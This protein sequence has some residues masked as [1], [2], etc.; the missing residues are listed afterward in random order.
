MFLNILHFRKH[1]ACGNMNN[2]N[3]RLICVVGTFGE[4]NR[5]PEIFRRFISSGLP[6]ALITAL[7]SALG[8]A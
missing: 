2:C 4:M 7:I 3:E 1:V 6:T 8:V 5:G